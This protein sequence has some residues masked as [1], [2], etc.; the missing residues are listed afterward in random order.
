M[1]A[2]KPAAAASPATK[3]AAAAVAAT[4]AGFYVEQDAKTRKCMVDSKKPDGKM[5]IDVGT[6][7]YATKGRAE[8]AMAMLKVCKN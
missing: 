2:T 4:A 8:Q 3:P 1:P 5:M 7:V 6:K